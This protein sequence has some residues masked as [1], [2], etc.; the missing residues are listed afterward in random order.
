MLDLLR[1]V[2][3]LHDLIHVGERF[4]EAYGCEVSFAFGDLCFKPRSAAFGPHKAE[5]WVAIENLSF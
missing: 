5:Q 4:S 3:P 1:R 2:K